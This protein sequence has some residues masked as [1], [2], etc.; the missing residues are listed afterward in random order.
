[1]MRCKKY[2]EIAMNISIRYIM[3]RYELHTW[4]TP[5]PPIN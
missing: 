5:L 3:I 2:Y 1:M 4:R